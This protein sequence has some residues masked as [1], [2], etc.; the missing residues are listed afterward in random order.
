MTNETA[1]TTSSREMPLEDVIAAVKAVY[2]AAFRASENPQH[3]IWESESHRFAW[4][5]TFV[6]DADKSMGFLG[7][8]WADAYSK[9][10]KMREV[11]LKTM[12]A[13]V[14]SAYNLGDFDCGYSEQDWVS[15]YTKLPAPIPAV[16]SSETVAPEYLGVPANRDACEDDC[17]D[18]ELGRAKPS[19]EGAICTHCNGYGGLYGTCVTC[20]GSGL[21]PKSHPYLAASPAPSTLYSEDDFIGVSTEPHIDDVLF[22][23][24]CA[25]IAAVPDPSQPELVPSNTSEESRL[26]EQ[27]F[28][29]DDV[30]YSNGVQ[31]A[32]LR[33][34]LKYAYDACLAPASGQALNDHA[35]WQN[36]RSEVGRLLS[37]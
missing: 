3:Y 18:D 11:S 20:H 21:L 2:P 16:P 37:K 29:D 26:R 9:L 8:D 22:A 35:K 17:T 34:L 5:H 30:I 23:D 4:W 19:C 33:E 27:V 15:A 13:T 31:I 12:I 1:P 36:W 32:H 25:A 7:F 28:S 6:E 14:K 10:P 24:I